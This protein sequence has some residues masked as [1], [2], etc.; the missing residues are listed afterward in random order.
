MGLQLII[1]ADDFGISES[2][3]AGICQAHREGIVTSTSLMSVGR[4]FDDAVSRAKGLPDLDIGVHL[5]LVGEAPACAPELVD[6]LVTPD[7]RF[8]DH[9]KDFLVRHLAG[10]IRYEQIA[11]E[12]ETQVKLILDTGLQVTHLDTHQHVHAIPR[13]REIVAELG[14][15]YGIRHMR[16]PA[17]LLGRYM[18]ADLSEIGRLSEL[19]ALNATCRLGNWSKLR[20]TNRFV[21]FFFGGRL[22]IGNLIALIEHLPLH[23][24]CELMCHPGQRETAAQYT[25]WNYDWEGEL[26]AMVNE[27]VRQHLDRRGVRLVSFGDLP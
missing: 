15:R 26:D 5:T 20:H 2:I 24:T 3:N 18:F 4:A 6:T 25:T 21:G 8:P 17:E 13:V 12:L 10:R 11:L 19:L 23:G 9:T 22:T 1:N 16:R 7:G 14:L 27:S